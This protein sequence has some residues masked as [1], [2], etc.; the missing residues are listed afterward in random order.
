MNRGRDLLILATRTVVGGYLAAHGAQKLFGAFGGPGM[1]A[2]VAGF[3]R[4]G[5]R[6]APLTAR[7][8]AISE[9]GGG[10]LTAAGAAHPLGP[11]TISGAMTVASVTHRAKGPSRG[12][13]DSSCR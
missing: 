12:A 7:V 2:T 8:A 6:P 5:L 4:L 11:I 10:V 1:D 9:F 3:R 13:V